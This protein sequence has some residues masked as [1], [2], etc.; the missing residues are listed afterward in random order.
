MDIREKETNKKPTTICFII[1]VFSLF[2]P[3]IIIK[4]FYL[5]TK[6]FLYYIKICY[7]SL[8][9]VDRGKKNFNLF[10]FTSF[11]LHICRYKKSPNFRALFLFGYDDHGFSQQSSVDHVSG[12]EFGNNCSGRLFFVFNLLDYLMKIGIKYGIEN[13]HLCDAKFVKDLV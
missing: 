6:F 2:M 5:E 1:Y 13:V 10:S 9:V 7:F 11:F 3:M 8:S 4:I 12:L